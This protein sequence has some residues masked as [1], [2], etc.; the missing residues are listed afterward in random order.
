[1][2]HNKGFASIILVAA[3]VLALG[4]VWYG[5]VNRSDWLDKKGGLALAPGKERPAGRGTEAATS[6]DAASDTWKPYS[7][8]ENLFKIRYP[9]IY[10]ATTSDQYDGNTLITFRYKDPSKEHAARADEILIRR[11]PVAAAREA[12]RAI[13]KDTIFDGSGENPTSFNQYKQV[14]ING[15]IFYY[16]AIG[17]F[18]GVLHLRYYHISEKYGVFS[19]D[20]IAQGV[21]WTNPDLNT[22][23]DS[24]HKV[25]KQMLETFEFIPTSRQ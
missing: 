13:M 22:N 3:V 19:F 23:D 11:I 7:N 1:M 6:S 21:D 24:V 8:P 17:R 9:S 12:Q 10:S 5:I 14:T 4:A 20:S 15:R 25:L 16:V 2:N 18:E